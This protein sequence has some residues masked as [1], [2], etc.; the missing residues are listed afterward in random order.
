MTIHQRQIGE[1]MYIRWQSPTRYYVAVFQQDLLGDW[2]LTKAHGGLQNRL[3]TLK[4]FALPS[5]EAAKQ[6][7]LRLHKLRLKRG[8]RLVVSTGLPTE[9][10]I[11]L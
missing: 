11:M 8:Y 7:L 6:E 1:H 10:S 9:M 4:N 2:V 3:G 5:I